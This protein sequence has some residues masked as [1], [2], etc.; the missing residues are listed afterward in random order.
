VLQ[1][2]RH[3]G[4]RDIAQFVKGCK[5]LSVAGGKAHA[6]AGQVRAFRQRLERHD[7]DEV[8]S[9]A[10]QRAARRLPCVDFRIALVAQDHETILVGEFL[11]ADEVVARGD[12]AL[13]IGGRG[14]E[15]RDGPGQR[16]VI[17]RIEIGQKSVGERGRQVDRFAT[18]GAGARAIGRIKR[19]GHQDRGPALARA[20]I[21]G[22]GDRREK[23]PFA[24][25]AQHQD[26][27]LGIDRTG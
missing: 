20:N 11:Q 1:R 9:G 10:F 15:H 21:S 6:H 18:G 3:L 8:R 7:I 13:R 22:G 19:V 23:Q 26:F 17:E 16:R 5:K 25:A 27:S 24:A 2:H 12:G 14:D 4:C